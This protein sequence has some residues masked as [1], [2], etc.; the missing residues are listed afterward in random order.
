M[1]NLLSRETEIR[2]PLQVIQAEY[3][4]SLGKSDSFPRPSEIIAALEMAGYKIV[5]FAQQPDK[6]PG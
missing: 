2:T 1:T 4:R 5:A 6:E 3:K